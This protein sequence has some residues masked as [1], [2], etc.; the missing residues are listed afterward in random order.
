M[1][2]VTIFSVVRGVVQLTDAGCKVTK[3]LY[4]AYSSISGLSKSRQLLSD[5]V[6]NIKDILVKVLETTTFPATSNSHD[7][8]CASLQQKVDNVLSE[9]QDIAGTLLEKLEQARVDSNVKG[10][11]KVAQTSKAFFSNR[12][13]IRNLQDR[14]QALQKQLQVSLILELRPL[15]QKLV[16]GQID[17][18]K[19]MDRVQQALVNA[20][21]ANTTEVDKLSKAMSKLSDTVQAEGHQTRSLVSHE[22]NAT[23]IQVIA[24]GKRLD[25]VHVQSEYKRFLEDLAF[26]DMG[27]REMYVHDAAPNTFKW[28]MESP[29]WRRP[30][31]PSWDDF[32]LWLRQSHA[33]YWIT[34]KAGSG[35]STLMRY[36]LFQQ[37][38]DVINVL[39][40][41]PKA[42]F[43]HS[44]IKILTACPELLDHIPELL[45]RGHPKGRSWSPSKLE[46]MMGNILSCA[47]FYFCLFIDGLDEFE[48][49]SGP[50][51]KDLLKIIESLRE[52]SRGNAKFCLSS[53]PLPVFRSAFE[54][55]KQ[56]E[57]HKLTEN[58]IHERLRQGIS[59]FADDSMIQKLVGK[60]NGVFLWADLAVR[61]LQAAHINGDTPEQIDER[62]EQLPDQLEAMYEHMFSRIDRPYRDTVALYFSLAKDNGFNHTDSKDRLPVLLGES[63]S[64]LRIFFATHPEYWDQVLSKWSLDTLRQITNGCQQLELWISGRTYGILEIRSG[65]GFGF[66]GLEK[67]NMKQYFESISSEEDKN[68]HVFTQLAEYVGSKRVTYAH[69]SFVDYLAEKPSDEILNQMMQV[70]GIQLWLQYDI[71]LMVVLRAAFNA[72]NTLGVPRESLWGLGEFSFERQPAI[73]LEFVSSGADANEDVR[74]KSEFKLPGI[75]Y[76]REGSECWTEHNAPFILALSGISSYSA[77]PYLRLTC[78]GTYSAEGKL[79]STFAEGLIALILGKALLRIDKRQN[80]WLT[81]QQRFGEEEGRVGLALSAFIDGTVV[82]ISQERVKDA[83]LERPV[84]DFE[85]K[86]YIKVGLPGV[87]KEDEQCEANGEAYSK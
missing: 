2:P 24:L 52:S 33:I 32:V 62:L 69:R 19:R 54:G 46:Q 27:M 38:D 85:Y 26:P 10:I 63:T 57:L 7:A 16:I 65:N 58:D 34:G 13:E 77:Q 79:T 28:V 80:P 23:R 42:F 39:K 74:A 64:V 78:R 31:Q 49:G 37:R 44:S 21:N 86:T 76:G 41:R 84:D 48:D 43:D 1:D 5:E 59:E 8:T 51:G 55:N 18:F 67:S 6:S 9:T 73:L 81:L 60:A 29:E 72:S 71:Q 14:F 75:D 61:S 15:A 45:W 3:E 87:S 50:S 82:E 12:K 68:D 70:P 83:M 53:R 22:G 36:L 56:L 30:F 66:Y 25:D 11:K 40:D 17:G 47:S 35:K 4:E 20:I